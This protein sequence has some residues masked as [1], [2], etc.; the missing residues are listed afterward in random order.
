[1]QSTIEDSGTSSR[2]GI[3]QSCDVEE[4]TD[5]IRK[6]REVSDGHDEA[7]LNATAPSSSS[8]YCGE[9]LGIGEDKILMEAV[10]IFW[11]EVNTESRSFKTF[12]PS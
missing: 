11:E 7:S 10:L 5:S 9:Q 1:M 4:E 8:S 3:S 12:G 6:T 2:P